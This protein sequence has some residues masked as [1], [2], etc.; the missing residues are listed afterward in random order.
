MI[1][2]EKESKFLKNIKN[3][4]SIEKLIKQKDNM[5]KLLKILLKEI[6]KDIDLDS[7]NN[8]DDSQIWAFISNNSYQS[9]NNFK[10]KTKNYQDILTELSDTINI[11]EEKIEKKNLGKKKKKRKKYRRLY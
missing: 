3:T 6:N 2:I 10:T 11:T 7:L 8:L 4:D 5:L 1:D 9:I